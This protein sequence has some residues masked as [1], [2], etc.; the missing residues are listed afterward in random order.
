MPMYK[1]LM[2]STVSV[3]VEIEADNEEDAKDQAYY[4]D[5]S[6]ADHDWQIADICEDRIYKNEI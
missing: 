4:E 6:W 2:I 3:E 1:V 5:L